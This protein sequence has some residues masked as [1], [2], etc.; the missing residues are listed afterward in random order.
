[1]SWHRGTPEAGNW[2]HR[3]IG[4][5]SP[6]VTPGSG[7]DKRFLSNLSFPQHLETDFIDILKYP[8][9]SSFDW[10]QASGVHYILFKL[11]FSAMN[12]VPKIYLNNTIGM[13]S[14][15]RPENLFPL[16]MFCWRS[17]DCKIWSSLWPKSFYVLVGYKIGKPSDGF[18]PDLEFSSV[19]SMPWTFRGAWCT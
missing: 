14:T 12:C 6:L 4:S 17:H 9:H 19:E 15:A 11:C 16:V 3:N 8:E 18:E 1:M 7:S 5:P 10:F 13:V 2:L